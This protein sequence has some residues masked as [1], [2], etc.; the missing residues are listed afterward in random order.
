MG[1]FRGNWLWDAS[2]NPCA[3][4]PAA[5]NFDETAPRW[6]SRLVVFTTIG[7]LASTFGHVWFGPLCSAALLLGLFHQ[8][9]PRRFKAVWTN[10]VEGCA[11]SSLLLTPPLLTPLSCLLLQV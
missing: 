11:I 2:A 5:G 6:F 8:P 7:V 3:V 9:V 10:S 1:Q 4:E